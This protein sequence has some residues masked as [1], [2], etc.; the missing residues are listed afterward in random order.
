MPEDNPQLGFG[1]IYVHKSKR[2]NI[3][4]V[5]RSQ[6]GKS[7]LLA[8]IINP[9]VSISS[10]GLS[11]TR[12]PIL[13]S[14][15]VEDTKSSAFYQLNIIDTPGVGEVAKLKKECRDDSEIFTLAN[16]FLKNNITSLNVVAFVSEASQ[17][18]LLDISVFEELKKFLGPKCSHI[19]MLLLTHCDQF[20]KLD[21]D[22]FEEDIDPKSR[23]KS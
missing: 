15:V 11:A 12:S 20:T 17:T 5:G 9:Q 6:A 21:L 8:T 2:V 22:K 14:L 4:L 3:L 10:T 16:T 19:S 23:N 13:A 1:N 7:T 18:H